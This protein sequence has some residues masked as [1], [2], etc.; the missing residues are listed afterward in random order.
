MVEFQR[1]VYGYQLL[2]SV[3]VLCE[4]AAPETA[5]SRRKHPQ[6]QRCRFGHGGICSGTRSNHR[7]AEVFA[8]DIVAA[9]VKLLSLTSAV[10]RRWLSNSASA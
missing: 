7:L 4:P 2:G 10:P 8:P 9:R 1:V 5:A 6:H 3:E